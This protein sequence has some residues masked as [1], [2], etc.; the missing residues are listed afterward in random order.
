MPFFVLLLQVSAACRGPLPVAVSDDVM[1][2]VHA[3]VATPH[4]QGVV[5]RHPDS[6]AMTDSPSIYRWKRGWRMSYIVFDGRGYETWLAE[7][8][9]LLHWTSLGRLLSFTDTG[10]DAH[11]KAGYMAL[12]DPRWGGTYR[13]RRWQGRYWMTYLGGSVKGYEAGRLGTGLA[14]APDAG[15]ALEWTRRGVPVL[16]SLDAD[17]HAFDN[18]TI[19]KSTV[20]DI[21][22][23]PTSKRFLMFYNAK[24]DTA[25]YESICLAASEDMV[26]WERQGLAPLVSRY[27]KGS[28]CGDAQVV[29]MGRL[30]VMF[31]FG[32]FWK[33]SQGAFERFACSYDL[34]HWTDWK[35]ANL[36]EPATAYDRTYA[37][38]PFVVK[39]RGVV[40]HFYNAVGDSGRVVALATSRPLETTSKSGFAREP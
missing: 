7:S 37:H 29:R 35:G 27:E 33:G 3:E 21:P 19:Y 24:G 28:I 2:S 25:R 13:P 31:Y 15:K 40:Y 5:F 36:I 22:R 16:S 4:R 26:Q 34:V 9:D 1:R 6:A 38:K 8:P 12:L 10:W 20:L 32:A 39:W 23:N 18:R 14:W 30:Y 17:A 11:Q